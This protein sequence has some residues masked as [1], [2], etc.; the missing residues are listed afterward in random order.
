MELKIKQNWTER[1]AIIFEAQ[2]VLNAAA[3]KAKVR[4]YV[5]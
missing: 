3:T 2:L 4:E 5:V 1:D